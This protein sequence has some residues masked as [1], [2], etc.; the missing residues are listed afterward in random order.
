MLVAVEDGDPCG[1]VDLATRVKIR[2]RK[3]EA[4][5]SERLICFNVFGNGLELVNT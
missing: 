1:P 2:G 4:A 3:K 5:V